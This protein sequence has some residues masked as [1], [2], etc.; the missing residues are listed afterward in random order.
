MCVFVRVH[1]CVYVRN[2]VYTWKYL[3]LGGVMSLSYL[4]ISVF[5]RVHVCV[6]V[7][8]CIYMG[9]PDPGR[10]HVVV[11]PCVANVLLICC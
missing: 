5:V 6:C 7:Y 2:Y 11:L 4:P 1:V 10:R 9:I 3:I 8:L